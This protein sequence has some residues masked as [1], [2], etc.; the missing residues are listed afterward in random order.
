M[1]DLFSVLEE[2]LL[3]IP[4]AERWPEMQTLFRKAAAKKTH[5]WR[6]PAIACEA[7]GG[8]ANQA[9]LALL[10]IACSH[11]GILLVDDMLDAD[12]RGE[13]HRIGEGRAANLAVGFQAAGLAALARGIAAP[14][15]TLTALCSLNQMT[16]TTALGQYMDAQNPQDVDT[17]WDIVRTKSSP[18]FGAALQVGALAG[19]V[20]L[21]TAAQIEQFGRLYGE[22]IQIHDDLG[23]AMATPANADWVL[24]R[25]S[26]PILFAQVVD[27]PDRDHFM[28]LRTAISDPDALAEAQAILIRCGAVS[29]C[30]DQLL[31][32]VRQAEELL[33]QI[34]VVSP[35]K[36]ERL[37]DDTVKPVRK[38]ISD[39]EIIRACFISVEAPI[40]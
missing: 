37:I 20:S 25:A 14:E 32:R 10:A 9:I 1:D 8:D 17:Y 26:L 5:H 21:D 3:G 12:P 23:D 38:L 30:I 15:A 18:F 6:L 13:H 31:H 29:Y 28:A 11:I 40:E 39:R 16:L 19:G 34:S 4:P 7:V 27:H 35:G 22:M 24:G 2:R 36:L 33:A